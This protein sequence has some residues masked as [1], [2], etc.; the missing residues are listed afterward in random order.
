[1]KNILLFSKTKMKPVDLLPGI[2]TVWHSRFYPEKQIRGAS[3]PGWLRWLAVLLLLAC[4]SPD[5]RSTSL[6]TVVKGISI[7]VSAD[8]G[9]LP[10][11]T[12][13]DV[14]LLT[15]VEKRGYLELL[16][17][18]R[19]ITLRQSMAFDITLHDQQ[20]NEIQPG[21]EVDVSFSGL[22]LDGQPEELVVFHAVGSGRNAEKGFAFDKKYPGIQSSGGLKSGTIPLKPERGK[23]K[24]S[25]SHFSI[26]LVGTTNTATYNFYVGASLVDTQIVLN[27]ESLFEPEAPEAIEGKRF[28]GWYEGTT[29]VVFNT[30][31]TVE[32]TETYTVNAN[33]EDIWYV[34]FKYSGNIIATKEVVPGGTVDATGVPLIVT[35]TG[36]AFLHWSASSGGSAFDFESPI[37][38][39]TTLYAVLADMWTVSFNTQGGSTTLPKYIA[40]G[41]PLGTVEDP[42]RPGFTFGGWYTE[43][44]GAGT[45][46]TS[47]TTIEESVILYAKWTGLP[48]DYTIIYWQENADDANYTYKE[49]ATGSG[50]AGTI[51]TLPPQAISNT[52]YQ[53]FSFDYYDEG[54]TLN[55]D[56]TTTVNVYYSRNSYTVIFDLDRTG[57]TL[58]IGGETYTG[59]EYT[60]TAKYDSDISALWPTAT[61]IPNVGL[62]KFTGWTY[63]GGSLTLVSKRMNFTPDLFSTTGTRTYEGNWAINVVTYELHYMIQVTSGTGEREYNGTW[64]NEDMA[65]NQMA[66]TTGGGWSAKQISGVTNVGIQQDRTAGPDGDIDVYFYY[67]RNSYNL[68]FYNYNENDKE[69]NFVF[70]AS[71]EDTEY[72]PLKPSVLPEGYTFGGWYDNEATSGDPFDFEGAVMP[73]NN[74]I[75][76]SKWI[77]PV[78]TVRIHE[79]MEDP[80]P[81]GNS[82]TL[83][84]PTGST[85]DESSLIKEEVPGVDFIGW[86]WYVGDL[87]VPYDFN[88]PVTVDIIELFPVWDIQTFNVTYVLN[89]G[90]GTAP[91]DPNNYYLG[92]GATVLP[93]TDVTPPSGKVF[94]G[95]AGNGDIYYP[96]QEIKLETGSVTLTAQWGDAA[97]ETSITYK[98]NG[99]DDNGATG[100]DIVVSLNNNEKHTVL[101]NTFTCNL[102]YQF[103]G[104]NTLADGT[105]TMFMP[106]NEVIVDIESPVP[107]IL[108]AI[109]ETKSLVIEAKVY[110]EG[111]L[112]DPETSADYAAPMRTTLNDLQMLPGQAYLDGETVYYTPA[113]QPYNTE[114]WNYT[115]NEGDLYDTGGS[116]GDAGYPATAVDW[117]LV[118]L[119]DS[120]G[121]NYSK[122]FEKAALLLSDGSIQMPEDFEFCDL[123]VNGTY[124]LVVE[125]RNHLITMSHMPLQI[126]NGILTYDF[127]TQNSYVLPGSGA[128]G[129]KEANGIWFMYGGNGNQSETDNSDTDINADDQSTWEIDNGKQGY[130]PGDYNMNGDANSNDQIIW[131]RNNGRTSVIRDH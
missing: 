59:S 107:N 99:N 98:P 113:G 88:L 18:D 7:T 19:G 71:I 45:E 97:P 109:W 29:Q 6:T 58:N 3:K 67:N 111:A 121:S 11:G 90:T 55:G 52:R 38:A 64:Y 25:T 77:T 79:V 69:L 106:G 94:V 61:N 24:F 43:P 5:A 91:V 72:T 70:G 126:V 66:N 122:V 129:Q 104:W 14:R 108:Y 95:W 103:V 114:P 75:L 96:N 74:L 115:G 53:Y 83:E 120:D 65:Y 123:D 36:K 26:Y 50:T 12:T 56:G 116:V 9:V 47:S 37:N 21:G 20:G 60:F 89:G 92:S 102:C 110:L 128:V 93:P 31:V 48:V 13:L 112:I 63:P 86:F 82:Y 87:F 42:I 101:D 85:I 17:S 105:G 2:A 81:G 127:T 1:M 84:L 33:F 23:L 4:F 76:Y 54:L 46:Y 44:D 27:G 73:P 16:R 35:E 118:S 49:T 78:Y 130:R 41:Q 15:N 30:P 34:Y 8:D 28:T 100:D 80:G 124:Y 117:V 62:Y 57:A 51:L 68:T 125:H 39:N 40:D 119:R 10:A 22:N 32:S 131:E